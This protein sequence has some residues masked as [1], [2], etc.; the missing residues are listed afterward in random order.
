MQLPDYQGQL[1]PEGHYRFQVSEEA[2]IRRGQ[3]EG[4]YMI[5]KFKIFND[6]GSS[7]KYNDIFVPWEER[8]KDL[9][10]ALGAKA[11]E[12]GNPHLGETEI[13]G[14]QFEADI[15]HIQDPRDATKT[16]DK[17]AN[18]VTRDDDVPPPS[19]EEPSFSETEEEEPPF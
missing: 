11:D 10:F 17:I 5:F 14:K 16:R 4:I 8:Y 9:L 18:I 19:Q 2:E 15:K 3:N 7:R 1:I 12:K 13:I 6:D